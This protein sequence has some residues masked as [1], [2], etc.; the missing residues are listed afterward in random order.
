MQFY[1]LI[2]YSSSNHQYSDYSHS[3]SVINLSSTVC[4][5]KCTTSELEIQA[6]KRRRS[7][8]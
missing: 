2:S 1:I 3:T 5:L 6:T 8:Q 7:G 4:P